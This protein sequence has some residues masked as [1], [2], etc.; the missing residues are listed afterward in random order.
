M[1]RKHVGRPR[2]WTLRS[3]VNVARNSGKLSDAWR[4]WQTINNAT[5]ELR[6]AL[7]GIDPQTAWCGD[8]NNRVRRY[9]LAHRQFSN[10][11]LP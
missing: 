2:G 6:R 9:I 3:L 4:G 8:R 1:T 5:H 10:P 11:R 7:L